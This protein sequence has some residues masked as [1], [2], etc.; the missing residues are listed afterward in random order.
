MEQKRSFLQFIGPIIGIILLYIL[1]RAAVGYLER[2][3]LE[4]KEAQKTEA[5]AESAAAA[6]DTV[7]G[8]AAGAAVAASTAPTTTMPATTDAM[9]TTTVVTATEPI[10]AA[11]NITDAAG[12]T[13]TQ[14]ITATAVVTSSESAI[15][16]TAITTETAPAEA[17]APVAEPVA[18]PVASDAVVA[19]I[20][21]GTCV[22]CHMIPG[23]PN[24]FGQ[25]GPNLAGIGVDGATRIPGYSAEQYI[26]E[27]IV[28]P[29][30][31]IAPK[32][33]FGSCVPGAMLANIDQ[34]LSADEIQSI[35]DYLLTLKTPAQ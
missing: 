23:V 3:Q 11:E 22:A 2:G 30:A 6:T 25:V 24:A 20:T 31:F 8:A 19:A 10:T 27:S 28:N 17:A 16:S 13:P 29:N 26:H 34:I 35:V 14:A 5:A 7:A 21:K 32:C 15:G 18:E 9:T 33:P 12:M 4:I 1:F